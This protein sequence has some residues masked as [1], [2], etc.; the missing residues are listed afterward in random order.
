MR[1]G[2]GSVI[3]IY[4]NNSFKNRF[5]GVLSSNLNSHS[6]VSIQSYH[7]YLKIER[8]QF[9]Q[10]GVYGAYIKCLILYLVKYF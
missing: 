3:E 4:R 8:G 2:I 10:S 6:S 5:F 9:V 7:K 1:G